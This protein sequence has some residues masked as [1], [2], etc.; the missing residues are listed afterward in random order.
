MFLDTSMMA[1]MLYRFTTYRVVW[2]RRTAGETIS[3][4]TKKF[5]SG[6]NRILIHCSV[7]SDSNIN[8]GT[9]LCQ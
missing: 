8:I 4:H 2:K 1:S 9:K 3:G 5:E 6:I 7:K